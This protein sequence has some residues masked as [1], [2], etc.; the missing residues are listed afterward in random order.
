MSKPTVDEALSNLYRLT[1]CRCERRR[2][3][4][5]CTSDYRV[6]VDVLAEV[7]A[8]VEGLAK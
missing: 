7:V 6:D 4:P 3:A 2:H 5:Q 8:H 1:D